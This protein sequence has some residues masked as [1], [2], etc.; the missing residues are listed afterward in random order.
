MNAVVHRETRTHEIES[1]VAGAPTLA[2][3][4]GGRG[5]DAVV[6]GRNATDITE[7]LRAD[8]RRDQTIPGRI[9]AGRR[10]RA[11]DLAGATAFHASPAS[12]R[13]D[14]VLP[15]DGAG[16]MTGHR[17]LPPDRAR[18]DRACEPGSGEVRGPWGGLPRD[19]MYGQVMRAG[20]ADEAS[21][22]VAA[23]AGDPRALDD[24]AATYLP[25][26]YAIVRRALG[27]L[28]DVDDVVQETMLRALPELRTLRAPECFRPWLVTIATRQIS[29]HLQRRQ[30]DAERTAPLDRM[31]DPP[32]AD[33][34]NLALLHVELSGH[35]RKTLRARRW[36]DPDARALLSLWW[37]ESAGRLTRVQL[38]AA[39]GTSVAHA[40]V[41][42]QRMRNQLE[43]SR[44]LVA[45]LDAGPRC[46]QLSAA[47]VGWD[48]VPS[49]LWR[50][51]I[52]RH[53]RSCADC[54]RAA[55]ELVPLERLIVALALLPV[56]PPR[57]V[58]VLDRPALAAEAGAGPVAGRQGRVARPTRLRGDHVG[59]GVFA[60]DDDAVLFGTTTTATVQAGRR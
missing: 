43:L 13:V 38:A 48:G 24:L 42:V 57:S 52:T 40:G 25:L 55:D 6:P 35:R 12:D 51:R 32:D 15:I 46:R 30:A 3:E 8:P 36:L 22:V 45:A 7:A 54:R 9:P 31:T 10:S 1:R 41:R 17:A 56:P 11:D 14:G 53:T 39:L 16:A 27:E 26:V 4:R 58:T 59:P 18:V 49:T 60:F 33:A 19:D 21:L 28:A 5:V 29:T 50:K 37:L 23:Q 2:K 47:L 20:R 34:E 44:S